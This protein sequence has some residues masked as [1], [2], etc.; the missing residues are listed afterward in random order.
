MKKHRKN[1]VGAIG[2][3]LGVALLQL[4]AEGTSTPLLIAPFGATFI[5]VFALPD[6]PLVKPKNVLG[7]YLISGFFGLAVL[8]SFGVNPWTLGLSVALA[9]F[10]MQVTGTVHPPAGAVPLLVMFSEPEWSFLITPLL[11][12]AVIILA[13]SRVYHILLKRA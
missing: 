2:A 10:A 5:L 6:S 12:G 7:G 13:F 1:F 9:L 8:N 11:V 3:L 4:L